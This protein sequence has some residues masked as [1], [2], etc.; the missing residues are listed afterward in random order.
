MD[1]DPGMRRQGGERLRRRVAVLV[2]VAGGDDG[3]RR[4]DRLEQAQSG[5]GVRAVM[6][7]LE[8][9]DRPQNAATDER[10]LHRRLGVAG[11]QRRESGMAQYEHDR[12]VVDV[13]LRQRG[14]CIGL[15]GE[16]DLER[17][18]R[19]QRQHLAGS[20]EP[21]LDGC[22]GRVGQQSV[23]GGILEADAGMQDGTDPM[24]VQDLDEPGDMILVRMAQDQQ[25]DPACEERRV[26][27]EAAQCQLRVRTPV[28]EHGAP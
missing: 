4:P 12:A 21:D 16:Q 23:E 13:A 2:V 5:G 3:E 18:R 27:T 14:R 1:A 19:I 6:S 8:H 22:G 10:C 15:R 20:G 28:D 11:Q 17:G 9:V 7:D 26:R 24:P 25:I